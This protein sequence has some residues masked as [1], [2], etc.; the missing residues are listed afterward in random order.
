MCS[1]GLSSCPFWMPLASPGGGHPLLGTRCPQTHQAAPPVPHLRQEAAL[2]RALAPLEPSRPLGRGALC[3][4][5]LPPA[6]ALLQASPRFLPL[7]G[8]P[9]LDAAERESAGSQRSLAPPPRPGHSRRE[10]APCLW[11]GGRPVSSFPA[12]TP[13]ILF[14]SLL[15]SGARTP[16][17]A[18]LMAE[19]LGALLQALTPGRPSTGPA[20]CLAS[21]AA[22]GGGGLDRTSLS[23][24]K[25][26]VKESP[27]PQEAGS[28]GRS[29][30]PPVACP[31]APASLVS[32]LGSSCATEGKAT[33]WAGLC[34]CVCVRLQTSS[35]NCFKMPPM[36]LRLEQGVPPLLSER[37]AAL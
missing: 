9:V 26:P 8:L 27:E 7:E 5:G 2:D 10:L 12:P 11:G 23:A 18:E 20:G 17:L 28:T 29:P 4:A 14:G 35:P 36:E 37:T 32:P 1:V 34:V 30:P 16:P 19:L 33:P 15:S 21:P 22:G 6:R 31:G 13:A 3:G 25:H 24:W